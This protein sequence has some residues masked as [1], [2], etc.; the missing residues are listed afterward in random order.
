MKSSII[1][2]TMARIAETT[3]SIK[4]AEKDLRMNKTKVKQLETYDFGEAIQEALEENP[5]LFP[6]LDALLGGKLS[7]NTGGEVTNGQG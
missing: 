6:K 3:G 2:Q 1:K 5:E 4:Q 7:N